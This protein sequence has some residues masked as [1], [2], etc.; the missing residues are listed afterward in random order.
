MT[1]YEASSEQGRKIKD[2]GED[3]GGGM[4]AEEDGSKR[5]LRRELG[6]QVM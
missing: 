4:G 2:R 3:G 5:D 1:G 6:M